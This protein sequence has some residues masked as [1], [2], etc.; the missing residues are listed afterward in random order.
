MKKFILFL[1]V[2]YFP[3]YS[4]AVTGTDLY[5]QQ[6]IHGTFIESGYADIMLNK[7]AKN[8]IMDILYHQIV[9]YFFDNMDS[10]TAKHLSIYMPASLQECDDEYLSNIEQEISLNYSSD[11]L[12]ICREDVYSKNLEYLINETAVTN[13]DA[14]YILLENLFKE[15]AKEIM[16]M[17]DFNMDKFIDILAVNKLISFNGRLFI[18][19]NIYNNTAN[20]KCENNHQSI[21]LL[22]VKTNAP[23][24]NITINNREFFLK[25]CLVKNKHN[26]F[27]YVTMYEKTESGYNMYMRMPVYKNTYKKES[28]SHY[29]NTLFIDVNRYHFNIY[30]PLSDNI[31][32][33]YDYMVYRKGTYLQ[34]FAVK[35]DD[36]FDVVFTDKT[37]G[38]YTLT[39][40]NISLNL[41]KNMMENY[42]KESNPICSLLQIEELISFSNN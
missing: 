26:Y 30:E 20:I 36:K 28:P 15:H 7:N 23:L 31:S 8:T 2:L 19:N 25:G 11:V 34:S 33:F 3:Y 13:K 41:F 18:D 22:D 29:I 21:N 14:Y 32:L 10:N 38:K 16:Q 4:F 35:N 39:E 5:N 12:S 24:D 17:K 1:F 40:Q 42:C 37:E 6:V 27:K 9:N